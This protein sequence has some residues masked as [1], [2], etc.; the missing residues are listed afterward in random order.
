MA[1]KDFFDHVGSD[2]SKPGDRILRQGYRW[3]FYA[4]NIGCG[5]PSPEEMVAG[6]MGSRGHRENLLNPQAEHVGVGVVRGVGT[7]CEIY[8]TALF[9]AGG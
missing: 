4:E 6:W 3:T 8:W 1:E 7:S 9:A 5:Y 2:G